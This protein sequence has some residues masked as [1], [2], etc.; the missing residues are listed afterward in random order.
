MLKE[1]KIIYIHTIGS[2]ADKFAKE[3]FSSWVLF[4]PRI[5]KGNFGNFKV[6][7]YSFMTIGSNDIY[8]TGLKIEADC[9]Y[10]SP[11]M[12]LREDDRNI[13]LVERTTFH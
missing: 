4:N 5:K 8:T 10:P 9:R 11:I 3:H 13:W 2:Q 6:K 12:L 7:K 1:R